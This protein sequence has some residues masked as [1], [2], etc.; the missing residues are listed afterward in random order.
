MRHDAHGHWIATAPALDRR[1]S[2]E[3]D[4]SCEYAVV[5]GGYT[6][7]WAAWWLKEAD[8]DADVVLIESEICGHGPSGRNG[9]F[10]NSLWFSLPSLA[11]RFGDGAALEVARL[12][13]DSVHRIGAWCTEQGVDARYR[14]GGYMQVSTCATRTGPGTR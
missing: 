9:G 7:M 6:G 10:C 4:T 5:G 13:D 8:P 1:P 3:G 14:K 11:A 12:A 2:L